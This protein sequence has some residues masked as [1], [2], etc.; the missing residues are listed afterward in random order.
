MP[1]T[2]ETQQLTIHDGDLFLETTNGE[3]ATVTPFRLLAGAL[4]YFRIPPTY[5]EDRIVKCQQ[6]G[7]NTIETYV[8]WNV[9]QPQRDQWT[10]EGW[11]DLVGFVRLVQKHGMYMI[12]RISPYIC[13]EWDNGG[14]P[15]WL[16]EDRNV[17][18]R[19]RDPVFWKAAQQFYDCIVSKLR[20]FFSTR[21]GH[22]LAGQLENEYGCTNNDSEYL[23]QHYRYLREELKVDIPLFNGIWAEERFLRAGKCEG[24]IVALNFNDQAKQRLDWLQENTS[25]KVPRIC[26]EFWVGW[27]AAWGGFRYKPKKTPEVIA[28]RL[29]ELLEAK[30][31]AI[32]YLFHGGTNF[33]MRNGSNIRTDYCQFTITSYDYEAPLDEAGQITPYYEALQ[34][35]L[36]KH[37]FVAGDVET[38]FTPVPPPVAYPS[39]QVIEKA[40]LLE[41]LSTNYF[42]SAMIR[43]PYPLT[44]EE[45][46]QDYGYLLYKTHVTGPTPPSTDGGGDQLSINELRDRAHVFIDGKYLETLERSTGRCVAQTKESFQVPREGCPLEILVEN[47][48]RANFP[49]FTQDYKGITENVFLG[50]CFVLSNWEHYSLD[51]SREQIQAL[52]W[53]AIDTDNRMEHHPC[54]CRAQWDLVGPLRDTYIR[55]SQ[56]EKG[57]VLVNGFNIGRYW[58]KGPQLSLYCPAPLLVE[59]TNEIIIFEEERAGTYIDFVDHLISELG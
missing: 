46:H 13:A 25:S 16:L 57:V 59:G 35:V 52:E 29:E 26:T 22:I 12:V 10:F 3:S 48:G 43:S 30:G 49:P 37:G 28:H 21:G 34:K 45:C 41:Q 14:I 7:C 32:L 31:H 2:T 8:A 15:Y 1:S 24:T 38:D 39:I 36:I 5:W 18:L 4:H 40:D 51:F 11:A 54:F 33:G 19:S 56:W 58:A 47:Q 27:F 17:R 55:L 44:M 50:D 23:E 6:M 9:H 53:S 42:Q 20:P